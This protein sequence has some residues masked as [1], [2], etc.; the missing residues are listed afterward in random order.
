MNPSL[1]TTYLQPQFT[2]SPPRTRER[3]SPCTPPVLSLISSGGSLTNTT[4]LTSWLTGPALGRELH[5]VGTSSNNY[6]LY[7]YYDKVAPMS[8]RDKLSCAVHVNKMF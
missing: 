8:S 7:I 1:R 4:Y 5:F 6:I 2:G 3:M